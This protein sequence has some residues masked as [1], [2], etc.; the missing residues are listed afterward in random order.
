MKHV[1]TQNV[2]FDYRYIGHYKE[3]HEEKELFHGGKENKVDLKKIH[4][5]TL[6]HVDNVF[7]RN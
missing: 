3:I 4:F 5:Y 2:S 7:L 1:V 6:T